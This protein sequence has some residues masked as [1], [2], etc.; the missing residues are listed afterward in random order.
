MPTR[1]LVRPP[2]TVFLTSGD[3]DDLSL[4]MGI[5]T[6]VVVGD[7]VWDDLD[8]DGVQ[9]AGE[10]GVEGVDVT[11]FQV[12]PFGGAPIEIGTETTDVDGLYSFTDLDPAEYYVVFDVGALPGSYVPTFADQGGDEALDS[13]GDPTTGVTRTTGFLPSGSDDLELD[14]GLYVPVTVGD[15]VWFDQSGDGIQ[16]AGEP[17]VECV[18]VTLFAVGA[19]GEP[20]TLDDVEIGT[21]TTDPD[22]AYVFSGL[23]PDAY[24]VVFDLTTI[25]EGQLV[26][27]PDQG[28]DDALDSDADRLTGADPVDRPGPL[29]G[30]F[31]RPRSR[32]GGPGRGRRPGLD[33]HRRRRHPR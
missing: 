17:G 26:T 32:S 6:P 33:R 3:P 30:E 8:G 28:T 16:D 5:F 23:P 31:P 2:T 13:D 20:G 22:G 1:S 4:D 25:P 19:D 9:D 11:L 7:F 14:L 10:P 15:R 12:D 24:Y 18:A 29:G 27:L 21:T